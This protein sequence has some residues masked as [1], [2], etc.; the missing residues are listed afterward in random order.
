[1]EPLPEVLSHAS[2]LEQVVGNLISNAIKFVPAGV[3]PEVMVWAE[4]PGQVLKLWVEDNGI[5]ISPKHQE[6]IFHIF[7][8]LHGSK[9]YPGTG[10]GWPW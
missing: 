8:R 2:T 9:A 6:R 1:M 5:G 4:Q 10:I 7:E 3:K